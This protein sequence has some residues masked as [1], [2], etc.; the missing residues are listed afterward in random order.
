MI[1]FVSLQFD[2]EDAGGGGPAGYA[3]PGG[4]GGRIGWWRPPAKTGGVGGGRNDG[5]ASVTKSIPYD[6]AEAGQD[7]AMLVALREARQRVVWHL[8]E[9]VADTEAFARLVGAQRDVVFMI[10]EFFYALR[11][12]NISTPEALA[13]FIDSH[14]RHLDQRLDNEFKGKRGGLADRLREGRFG[15]SAVRML[16]LTLGQQ[17]R[18]ELSQSDVARF[19][20]EVM[21]DETCRK[22]LASL[23]E[24]GLLQTRRE[25]INRAVMVW[26]DGTL[27]AAF[28]RHLAEIRSI[29]A[30]LG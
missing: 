5:E 12:M 19:L 1:A 10:A 25:E 9:C 22:V 24:I 13:A 14:N 21:S 27:E 3:L 26:S 11:A 18:L 23:C 30:K 28:G 29:A 4:P 17:G 7:V 6:W 2:Q 20:V 16:Q 8:G 15:P